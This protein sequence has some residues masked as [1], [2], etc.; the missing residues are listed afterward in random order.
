MIDI[1]L[2]AMATLGIFWS[3]VVLIGVMQ[4]A[5][6]LIKKDDRVF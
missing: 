5:V 2:M 4:F 6:D 1:V 3:V